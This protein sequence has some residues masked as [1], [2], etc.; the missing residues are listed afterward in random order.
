[1]QNSKDNEINFSLKI[2]WAQKNKNFLA[3]YLT[4]GFFGFLVHSTLV[5]LGMLFLQEPPRDLEQ[6]QTAPQE[7]VTTQITPA[8]Q[9]QCGATVPKQT[10]KSHKKIRADV[11]N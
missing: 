6:S 7:Q 9:T 3:F 8:S 10:E 2:S 5:V 1:M 11:C 4:L